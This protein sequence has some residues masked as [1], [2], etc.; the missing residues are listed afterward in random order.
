VQALA[1]RRSS[2]PNVKTPNWKFYTV[3]FDVLEPF[4]NRTR[5]FVFRTGLRVPF[6]ERKQSANE[7]VCATLAE[8]TVPWYDRRPEW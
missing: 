6:L 8:D 3:F 7:T 5:R 2:S 1:Q 4:P